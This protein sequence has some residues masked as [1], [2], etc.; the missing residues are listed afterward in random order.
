MTRTCG[1]QRPNERFREGQEQLRTLIA[2]RSDQT[3]YLKLYNIQL[4]TNYTEVKGRVLDGANLLFNGNKT[5]RPNDGKFSS[6]CIFRIIF[7]LIK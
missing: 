3:D 5:M 6:I 1:Q 7:N 4:N 2:A